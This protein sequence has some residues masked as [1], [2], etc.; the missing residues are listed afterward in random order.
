MTL[1]YVY[2]RGASS[3]CKYRTNRVNLLDRP[4]NGLSES[5]YVAIRSE[6]SCTDN[7]NSSSALHSTL[8]QSRFFSEK[9][10]SRQYFH[11]I[12]FYK[13]HLLNAAVNLKPPIKQNISLK[14]YISLHYPMKNLIMH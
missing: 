14:F 12:H 5:D 7:D 11:D 10:K 4:L 3:A 9:K 6:R 8:I 13:S 1:R 2:P